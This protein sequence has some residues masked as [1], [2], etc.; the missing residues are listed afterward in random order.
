M[1]TKLKFQSAAHS[2]SSNASASSSGS[3]SDAFSSGKRTSHLRIVMAL[4]AVAILLM[5]PVAFAREGESGGGS[6]GSSGGSGRSGGSDDSISSSDDDGTA[7]QGSGD[8]AV[9]VGAAASAGA[10]VCPAN[11]IKVKCDGTETAREWRGTDGCKYEC[12]TGDDVARAISITEANAGITASASSSSSTSTNGFV[13]IAIAATP[14]EA[15][16]GGTVKVAGTV[17]FDS[18]STTAVAIE[19]KFKVEIKMTGME[20][21]NSG[22]GSTSS[23]RS[24][25][26]SV[27][28]TDDDGTADQGRGDAPGATASTDDDGTA[29]QGRGDISTSRARVISFKEAESGSSNSGRGSDDF[30]SATFKAVASIFGQS[31]DDSSDDGIRQEDKNTEDESS[32]D[33]R[34][35]SGISSSTGVVTAVTASN[36]GSASQEVTEYIVLKNGES[37]DVVAYFKARTPGMKIVK[38]EVYESTGFDCPANADPAATSAA[39]CRENFRKVAEASTKVRVRGEMPPPPPGTNNSTGGNVTVASGVIQMS[40]G[41]NM[42][43]VPVMAKVSMQRVQEACGSQEFAWRLTANGYVKERTMVPGYGY[44]VKAG[45]DCKLDVS[46]DSYARELAQL[47]SGWNLVGAP[48]Q[49][50]QVVSFKG[51]CDI[52]A[53]PWHYDNPS[54]TSAA[55]PYSLS[56]TLSPGKAYWIKVSSECQLGSTED[57]PPVPPA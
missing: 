6:S 16:V 53:G 51:N 10:A 47:S 13:K 4:F 17:G 37:K 19:K 15:Q 26:D 8:V 49:E 27:G 48:G 57:I 32:D 56:S 23:G 42:V 54:T 2:V 9:S 18:P 30:I 25:D 7:D 41:W 12:A 36:S 55:N 35:R 22:P 28:S 1:E 24:S 45:N 44:W 33:S 21:G 11:T 31:S 5:A 50:V 34:G 14:Q 46:A 40:S 38:M 52:T 3:M 39:P 20:S 43:S 29:D